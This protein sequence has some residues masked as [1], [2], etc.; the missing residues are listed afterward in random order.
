VKSIKNILLL[1][2]TALLTGC[3]P[4]PQPQLGTMIG[5]PIGGGYGNQTHNQIHTQTDSEYGMRPYNYA[6][7]IKNYFATK[8][9]RASQGKYQFSTPQRAYRRKGFVY[10]GDIAWKGWMVDVT[11][12]IPSR[13]GRLSSPKPYMVLFSGEQIIDHILGYK[14]ELLTKVDQ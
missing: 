4:A 3:I 5:T 1:I 8:L 9:P 2:S 12:S 10:G 11:V 14:H 7:A 13:S 6:S